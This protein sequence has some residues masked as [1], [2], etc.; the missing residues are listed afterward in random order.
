MKS[1]FK[2]SLVI[3]VIMFVFSSC[4]KKNDEGK[5]IPANAMFVAQINTKSMSDKV[6]WNDIKQTSWFKKVYSDSATPEWRKKILDN[7][8]ASGIDFD[9]GLIFFSQKASADNYIFVVEGSLKSEKDFEE[10][11]KNFDP[12]QTIKKQGD[13]NLLTLKDKNIVGWSGNRFAYVMN[14]KTTSAEMYD[15]ND[16]TNSPNISPANNN[17]ELAIICARLFSLKSDSSLEKNEKFGDL[18][19]QKGDIHFWQNTEEIMKNN[20]SMGMLGMAKLDAFLKDNISTYTIS[21]DNG[22]I[23]VNQHAYVSRELT[24]VLKKYMTGKINTDMIKDIPSQNVIAVLSANFKPG[25][26]VELIKLTGADG[27][28]NTYAQQL[29]FTLD[30][31]SKAGN[32]DVLLAV[33]DLKMKPDSFN[34]KDDLG[35]PLGS[36][37]FIK[38]DFNYIFSI[39]ISDKA[40][41][42]K[43]IDAGKKMS[44]QLGK[45]SLLHYDMNDKT[46]VISSS[47]T[48]SK[49][50]LAGGNN[51][52]DFTDKINGH[53]IGLFID[54]QKIFSGLSQEAN[55]KMDSKALMEQNLKT[56]KNLFATAGD[57]K[58]GAFTGNAEINL[59]DQNLNSLKQ[60]N[61]Y[62]DEMFKIHEEKKAR[63]ANK[64]NLDSLL[65]P[66]PIDTVNVK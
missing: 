5:M 24:D 27:I 49:Q 14:A 38:P 11:N 46:F 7:P 44:V 19:T 36:G 35:N 43:I 40:S 18:L 57:Y 59:V 63:N 13:V 28:I 16:S 62:F 32:G 21:F 51:K 55:N 48:F 2:F 31:F 37:K 45:D 58:D 50:Y 52:Y 65:T 54:F 53:P 12:S 17:D 60:L 23:D 6:S 26:I 3:V 10:F 47:E 34:Y 66:P 29:G 9:K 61:I 20:P 30:D 42:Q 39:G 41:L 56:W 15:L 64:N 1:L 22:K 4:G 8:S 33:S 25:G